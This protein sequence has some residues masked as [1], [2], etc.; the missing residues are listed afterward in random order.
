MRTEG[1]TKIIDDSLG[2]AL[3]VVG[4]NEYIGWY[5]QT[6]ESADSTSW[7]MVYQKPLII[8][9]FGGDARAGL[10]GG[11]DERWTEEYQANIYR[12]QFVMLNRIPQL[13][14][15]SPWVLMDFRSPNRH[16][17]GVQDYFNRKG[18]VSQH[19]EKKKAFYVLQEFY[20]E[21]K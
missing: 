1:T 14:G 4:A 7:R 5:E 15:M 6:S 8:S 13:R 12:H 11:A 19:G 17:P 21:A 20:R 3:D 18:L 10:H 16:L 2:S 9:E